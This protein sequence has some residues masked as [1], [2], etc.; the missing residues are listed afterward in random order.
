MREK[1]TQISNSNR[2][3]GFV[4]KSIVSFKAVIALLFV[5]FGV[6]VNFAQINDN[7]PGTGKNF[8]VPAGVT[9]VTASAWGAGGGAGGSNN[10]STGG[11]GGGGGGATARIIAVA[12][13]NS[14]TYSVGTAGTGG[15]AN[16]G[17][18]TNGTLSSIVSAAPVTNMIANGGLGGLRNA[19][20][21]I[22]GVSSTGGTASG[23]AVNNS[24]GNGIQGNGT[25]GGNGG[26]SGTVLGTFGTGGPG[27]TGV[28]NPGT[29]PGAGG[30]GGIRNGGRQAGGDGAD[31]RVVFQYIGVTNI[32][33]NP[34]CV[35]ST[36]TITGFNF[37]TGAS[38]VTING[39]ACTSVTRVSATS[40]TAVVA[41]GTTSGTVVIS[42]PNGTNN[43]QTLTVNPSPAAILG[44]AATVCAGATTPAFTNATGG[45]TW[46]IVNGTGSATIAGT[47][48]VT[49]GTA[50]T[51]TVV[52]TLP[53]T[54]SITRA[55]TILATPSITTNPLNSTI[56]VGA[57]TSFTVAASNSPTSYTW[58]VSTNGG[59]SWAT[60][61]N[62]GVYSGATTA[63]LALTAVPS[64]MS[65]YLY[66]ASATTT[67]GTSAYSTNATLT[68]TLAYC[69]PTGTGN[70]YPI[71]NVTFAGIN[72]TTSAA[73]TATPYYQDF[74]ATFGNVIAG[75]TYTFTA[76]ATGFAG[77]PF[78]VYVYFDWNNNGDFTDDG[79]PI[80]VG[81]YTTA[82]ATVSTSVIIPITAATPIRFRVINQFNIVPPSCP[83]AG[84]LQVEDY[85]LNISPPPVCVA[86]T[87]RPTALVL[88]P[89]SGVI[90]GTFTA[91][92][93]APNSYLVV[94]S[95]SAT[96]PAG[97]VNGTTYT[98]GS[99]IA[100]GY[101]VVDNDG[102]TS[103]TASGLAPITTYYFY[104]YSFNNL[105]TG[106]PL[107]LVPS[108][109]TGNATT[110]TVSYCI[111]TIA[112]AYQT[113]T[114]FHIRRVEFIGTL[115]DITNTSS[116]PT[117]APFG[118]TDY[119][120]LATK[121]I[122]A[123]GQGVNIYVESPFS[124]YIKAWVDWNK[125]G[126]FLDTGETVYDAGGVSQAS[127]TLGFI[128]P[129]GVLAGN[130]RVRLRISGRNTAGAD[131]GFAWDAC[132]TNLAYFGEAEDYILQ[133]VDNCAA[134]IS[135][136]AEGFVCGSGPVTLSA[137]GSGTSFNWYANQTGGA[138]LANTSGSWT[139]PSI[140]TT[141]TY[142]VTAQSATCESLVRTKIRAV[143]KPTPTLSFLTST[144]EVCGE[145][146]VVALTAT[147]TNEVVYLLDE[148]FEGGM[149][150]FTN[151]HYVSNPAVNATTAWQVKT[152]P[153]IPTGTTWFPAIQSNFGP[154][155]FAF[156]TSDIGQCGAS[157]Y[158]T[159]DN[160][161]VS[162]TVNS[163][164]FLNLTLS[165]EYIMIDIIQILLFQQMS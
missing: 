19:S 16:I 7:T 15:A 70:T 148:K 96:P 39:T 109:L 48:I 157:C 42:N 100:P 118:Y 79:A 107:Y 129:T 95:T 33:P 26:N 136:I 74:S 55:I 83:T 102:N 145:D 14:F 98:I 76:T 9:S 23:G 60:V 93:P 21:I 13:T 44:G 162:N 105:C 110:L 61:T 75:Q 67:C 35:G 90:T 104:I 122:Q 159:V 86:P 2:T 57:N 10:N 149:G 84:T 144:T 43:G 30:G 91:A 77:Q 101:T 115:Q 17:D 11:N 87:A 65:G 52:Y 51:A 106:G 28:S 6:Q 103:F 8:T 82:T 53:T 1:Y 99:A 133:V 12:P 24:G 49:G 97:P 160:G 25:N 63:T 124:G 32:S 114:N 135:S 80:T 147:G 45:G 163:T 68:V 27:S 155:N 111:P 5:L 88:T 146:S 121:S 78:G 151:V 66:R 31:G 158:Y 92:S 3:K 138:V 50:G 127:T 69:T 46:S 126:D 37:A 128:V 34:V 58:Q 164:G 56:T 142:W 143:V 20:I 161:L 156:V 153:Y 152:S 72:N 62:G 132:T 150:T 41:A 81:T 165:L 29:S 4:S 123:K 73:V 112:N 130:Y 131:A 113:S 134:N 141:T 71:S 119:T 59:G 47:G 117:V 108:P 89:A 64:S 139:T 36:I 94:I 18:G 137:T 40:I 38:T 125:D 116:F 85:S 140:S 120:G 154:N 54:C 22:A